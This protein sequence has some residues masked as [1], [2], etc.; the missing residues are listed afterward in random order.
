MT[1]LWNEK[2]GECRGTGVLV[3]PSAGWKIAQDN[4]TI[5]SLDAM[6]YLDEVSREV[7]RFAPVVHVFFGKA[8]RDF[9]FSGYRV[10]KGWMVLWGHRSSHLKSEI[11]TDPHTFDPSRFS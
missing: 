9:E 8:R 4:L 2:Y 7:R 1:S 3:R 11:Y 5:D 10:P 6:P